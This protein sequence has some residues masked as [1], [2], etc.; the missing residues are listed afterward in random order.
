MAAKI[1]RAPPALSLC[2]KARK[3]ERSGGRG[4]MKRAGPVVLVPLRGPLIP[5]SPVRTLYK[6]AVSIPPP[7]KERRYC[8]SRVVCHGVAF[9]ALWLAGLVQVVGRGML[10]LG[11]G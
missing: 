8:L 2:R 10:V 11:I 6:D 1:S 9:S 7:C 3:A 4:D 5:A